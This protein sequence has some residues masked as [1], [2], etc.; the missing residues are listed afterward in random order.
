MPGKDRGIIHRYLPEGGMVKI[1]QLSGSLKY[2]WFDP[3]KGEFVY[4]SITQAGSQIF[5]PERILPGS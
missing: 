5:N 4:E 1:S 3:R 2:Q